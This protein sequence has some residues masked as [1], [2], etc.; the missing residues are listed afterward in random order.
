MSIHMMYYVAETVKPNQLSGRKLSLSTAHTRLSA[1]IFTR[2]TTLGS[3]D[4]CDNQKSRRTLLRKDKDTGKLFEMG[5][6]KAEAK[7][8]QALCEG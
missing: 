3:H 6:V 4:C 1:N 2:E 8:S 5:D 7:T